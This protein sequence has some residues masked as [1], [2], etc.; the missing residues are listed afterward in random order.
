VVVLILRI[1]GLPRALVCNMIDSMKYDNVLFDLDGTLTDSQLGITNSVKYALRK[2]NITGEDE[3]K[4][5]LFIGPPLEKS[6]MEY[7][8]FTPEGAKKA[9]AYYREYF[10]EKGIY[11]N[12]LYDGIELVLKTLND[13]NIHCIVATSKPENFA[14]QIVQHFNIDGFFKHIAGSGLDGSL[15]E[16]EDVIKHVIEKYKLDKEKTIMVGDRKYDITGAAK[17]GIRSVGVLYG[18]GSREELEEAKPSYLCKTVE[19]LLELLGP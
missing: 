8:G 19:G 2:F 12:K 13:K 11:E 15:S 7:C 9:V 4:L 1:A 6:F 10:S 16:K 17:N 18:Y 3:S 14:V 5:R